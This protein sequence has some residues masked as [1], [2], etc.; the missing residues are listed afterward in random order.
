MTSFSHQNNYPE[1]IT[2]SAFEKVNNLTQDDAL[3]SANRNQTNNRTPLTLTYHPLNNRIKKIIYNNFHLLSNDSKAKKIFNAPPLMAFRR[4]KNI[5]DSLVR[6]N[7]QSSDSPGTLPC[8]HALCQTCIHI[9]STTSI[10]KGYKT[11]TIKATFT[12]S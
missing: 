12:C 11:F 1:N 5:K 3:L 4:D 9:N 6:T 8:N 7:L 2:T 10:S